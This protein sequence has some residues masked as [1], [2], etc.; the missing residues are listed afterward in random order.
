MQTKAISA[1]QTFL[2]IRRNVTHEP[3]RCGIMPRFMKRILILTFILIAAVPATAIGRRRAVGKPSQYPPC[4]MITGTAA[5]TFTHDFGATL[6]PSAETLRPIAYTYGLAAMIDE[7]DTLMAW[8]GDDHLI[9]TNAGCSWRVVES[10]SDWDFPPRLTPAIGGRM[11]VWSDNRRYLL[12]YD[13]RGLSTLKPPADFVGLGVDAKNGERLRAAGSDG[14]IWESTDA[15]ESWTRIA[16]L[17]AEP[18][19]FYRFAFDA[20]DLDHIVAGTITT[21]A[22]V[23]RDGGRTWTT[24]TGIGRANIFELAIS[25]ADSNRVWAEGIDLGESRRHIYLSNDGGATYVPVVDESAEIDLINGNVMA[26]HPT[27]RDVLYFVFG[28][29]LFGYGTDLFRYDHRSRRVTK[30]HSQQDDINAIAFSRRDANLIYLG[31]EA[32]D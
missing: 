30:T 7:A 5:V 20:N 3:A 1:T 12:R 21:G 16:S 18:P 15:G 11:Y 8:H 26:P 9:S 29:H 22:H 17:D 10:R 2:M 23:T 31:L 6:A 32:A 14:S 25:P 19:L 24:A 13:S 28:T 4:A 27:N